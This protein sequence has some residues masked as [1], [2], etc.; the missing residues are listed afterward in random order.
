[1]LHDTVI[2]FGQDGALFLQKFIQSD[3]A[4]QFEKGN[5]KYIA[6]KSGWE[7]FCEVEE[8]VTDVSPQFKQINAYERSDAYWVGW[9]LVHCL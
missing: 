9:L 3:V 7:V 2:E 6:G 4:E 8:K 5:P 1:M